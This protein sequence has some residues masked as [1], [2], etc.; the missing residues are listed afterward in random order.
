MPTAL[1]DAM[2]AEVMSATV[3]RFAD[4]AGDNSFMGPYLA[5]ERQTVG[6]AGLLSWDEVRF[7]RQ[8]APITG[9]SSPSKAARQVGI[10]KRYGR[11]LAIKQHV[12]LPW[13]NINAARG[14]GSLVSDPVSHLNNSLQDLTNRIL[15]TRNYWASKSLLTTNGQVDP[16]AFPQSDIPA[17]ANVLTYPVQSAS[18]VDSWALPATQIRSDEINPLKLAY[19]K[20]TGFNP[21]V[22]I[23]S[24]TLDGYLNGN[25]E[26]NEFLR[27]GGAAGR[28]AESSYQEGN[29]VR[30]GGMDWFF[31]HDTYATDAAPD[32]TVDVQADLDLCAVLPPQRQWRDSF[33][34]AEGVQPVP[35]GAISSLGVAGA[36]ALIAEVTGFGAYVELI[37]NPLGFRLHGFWCGLLVQK[38]VD[39]VLVFNTTP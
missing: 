33:L 25:V 21:G 31:A 32:T 34:M 14:L 28:Q 18:A 23:G 7:S 2:Q 5:G 26:F 16:G 22:V 20:K 39:H 4:Q 29:G 36:T 1:D 9:P 27:N 13:L 35:T 12:D 6:A 15:R 38:G 30:Y 19:R 8:L 11:V 10:T 17:S 3:K 37:S 24:D